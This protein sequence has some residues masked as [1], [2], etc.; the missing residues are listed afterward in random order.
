M[1]TIIGDCGTNKVTDN[2]QLACGLVAFE[3]VASK[4]GTRGLYKAGFSVL[5]RWFTSHQN[6]PTTTFAVCLGS[7]N[8]DRVGKL[9]NVYDN[10]AFT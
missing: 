8:S 3:T 7:T 2:V 1:K 6:K 4:T 10:L 5:Q 9:K